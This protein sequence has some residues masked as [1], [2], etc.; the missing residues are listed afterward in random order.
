M[1]LTPLSLSLAAVLATGAA[2]AA[3]AQTYTDPQAEADYQAKLQDYQNQQNSYQQQRDAYDA[4]RRNY[5]NRQST[6]Q[7][8]RDSYEAQ[9]DQYADQRDTY[10]QDRSDYDARYGAGAWD[11]RYGSSYRDRRCR[12]AVAP[13]YVNG[14]TDY[15]YVRVCPDS[16][17]RYRITG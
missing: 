16:R 11:R 12:L 5:E 10:Q 3:M 4:Q 1:K 6:Y 13:A 8:R 15:R 17:G 7:D 9:R 14:D 2:G